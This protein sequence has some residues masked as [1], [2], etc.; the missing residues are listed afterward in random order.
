MNYFRED[1]KT[2]SLDSDLTVNNDSH[3]GY[4]YNFKDFAYEHP[5]SLDE[6]MLIERI[7]I[8]QGMK[9]L[10][11]HQKDLIF[12]YYMSDMTQDEIAEELQINQANVSRATKRGVKKLRESFSSSDGHYDI[13]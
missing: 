3:T 12:M 7:M 1:R 6:D 13:S 8:E 9:N 10:T 4:T 2:V 5:D 11:D